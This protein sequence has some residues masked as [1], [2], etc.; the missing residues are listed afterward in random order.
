VWVPELVL[1]SVPK[2]SYF[3]T[4]HDTGFA[5]ACRWGHSLSVAGHACAR[6][7]IDLDDVKAHYPNLWRFVLISEKQ[8]SSLL[9]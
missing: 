3:Y 7:D 5:L 1:G 2:K 4:P 8:G 6:V 9:Y